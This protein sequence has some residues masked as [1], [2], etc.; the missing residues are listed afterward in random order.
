[1]I[2]IRRSVVAQ[3]CSLLALPLLLI[4][5]SGV[6]LAENAVH[7][8]P[9]RFTDLAAAIDS[10]AH[11]THQ[12]VEISASDGTPLHAWLFLPPRPHPDYVIVLHGVGDSKSGM[13]RLIRM[14]LNNNFAVLAPDSRTN[15]VTYGVREAP[16]VHNWADFLFGTQPV[17]NLYG[18]GESMGAAVLLQSLALEPRLQ[19]VVAESPFYSFDAVAHDRISQNLQSDSWLVRAIAGP[20]VAAGEL[21]TRIRYGVDLSK[22]SPIE[23]VRRTSTPILLIHGL[24]DTNVSPQHSRYL[25]LANPRHITPWFVPRAGHAGAYST[26]PAV[27]EQRVTSFFRSYQH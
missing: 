17:H 4:L 13:H 26:D 2:P 16:D 9:G 21:Y 11:S 14:L 27:F 22:A 7:P 5:V 15:L 10:A 23:V 19:A 18:L 25:L 20:T 1:V 3:I 12:N 6:F 24:L 8:P